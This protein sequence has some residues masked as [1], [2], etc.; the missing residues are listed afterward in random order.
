MVTGTDPHPNRPL[1]VAVVG[2]DGCGKTSTVRGMLEQLAVDVP[3]AG[4]GDVVLTGG[5]GTELR[6]RD[7]IPLSKSARAVGA[8]AK[9]LR[10]PNLY[11]NLKLLEFTERT[12]VRNYLLDREHPQVVVG[13]GD[14]LVNVAAWAAARYLHD[15][16]AGDD[17]RLYDLL[18][19]VAG[20]RRV[21]LTELGYYLRHV[22]QLAVANRLHIARFPFPDM[23]ILLQ[24]SPAVS[25]QRIRARGRDLQA[26]ENETFLTA[27]ANAYERV[28]TLL[29]AR[30]AV[31]VVILP[32]DESTPDATV[33]AAA[34]AVRAELAARELQPV[35]GP[36]HSDTVEV[37]ATT[38]SGSFEDQRKVA[39]IESAFQAVTNRPVRLHV[40]ETHLDAERIAQ[41]I[42]GGGGRTLVSAGGAGTFN[43]VLEGCHLE[44]EIPADLR[45]AFLRKGSADL[46]GKVLH[47]PDDLEPA[48]AAIA[49]S[50]EAGGVREADVLEVASV[51]ADGDLAVRHIVGFGGIGVFGEVP[52]FT[53]NRF[54]KYYK[55]LLGSL[56]G[57]LGPFYV[58]LALAVAWWSVRR[59]LGRAPLLTVTLDGARLPAHQSLSVILLNGDLGKDFPLGR[60]LGLGEDK[61]RVV[62]LRH[63][64]VRS[65]LRQLIGSRSGALLDDPGTHDAIVRDVRDLVVEPLGSTRPFMV[66]VDGLGVVT[67]GPVRVTVSG[68]VQL[69]DA[70]A[71]NHPDRSPE[72]VGETG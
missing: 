65:M 16:L 43:A 71:P 69:V 47:V 40:A 62:V 28:C 19:Y 6:R 29:T 7:D 64:G 59:I 66:N 14:P 4:L 68:R 27:L 23:V 55:G 15:V 17:A 45:L 11:K 35:A 56:L 54:V 36:F 5:P 26:H 61:F 20:T 22:W 21:P 42:V 1:V 41:A 39:R 72:L 49:A 31:P 52:R 32:V 9:G 57:D 2:I 60:G 33:Q 10:R 13:D 25:M 38:M 30:C 48:A 70:A 67:P 51:E 37:I 8:V 18:H 46:I 53:E 12:H 58:G 50:I 63:H 34:E 3:V 44:G 24:I